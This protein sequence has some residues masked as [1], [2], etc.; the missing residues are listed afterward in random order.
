MNATVQYRNA[1]TVIADR[2]RQYTIRVLPDGCGGYEWRLY[3]A[4][5]TAILAG[6]FLSTRAAAERDARNALRMRLT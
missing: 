5:M 2:K 1:R 4:A 3:D 6:G